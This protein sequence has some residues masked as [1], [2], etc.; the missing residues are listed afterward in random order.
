VGRLVI[1]LTVLGVLLAFLALVIA[2]F[3][4]R[5]YV[6]TR[7]LGA[8]DCS[9]RRE[10]GHAVG[11]WMLGVARYEQDRLDW[12]R[13]FTLSFRPV[14][15]SARA[16]LLIVD[17]RSPVGAEGYTVTPGAVIVECSYGALTLEFAMSELAANGFATWLESAPPGQHTILA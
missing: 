6:L 15:T 1:P 10:S 12:F 7:D 14:R 9:L 16:R 5:R 2:L 11:G 8:F 3:I 17:R 4:F 13:I